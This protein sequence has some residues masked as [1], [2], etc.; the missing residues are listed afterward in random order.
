MIKG[1]E[2]KQ[3]IIMPQPNYRVLESLRTELT[4]HYIVNNW[5]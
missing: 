1:L 4:L 5:S 2:I 3:S